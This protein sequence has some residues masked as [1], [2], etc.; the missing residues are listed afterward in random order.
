MGDLWVKGVVMWEW[1]PMWQVRRGEG[2]MGGVGEAASSG[3]VGAIGAYRMDYVW[4]GGRNGA[5]HQ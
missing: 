2:V 4:K 3:R 1:E 5:G